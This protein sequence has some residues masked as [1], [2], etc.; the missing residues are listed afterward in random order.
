M[1]NVMTNFLFISSNIPATHL[2][3]VYIIQLVHYSSPATHLYAVY[4]I[5]LVHYSRMSEFYSY[6]LYSASNRYMYAA[7]RLLPSLKVLS[8][9]P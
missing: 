5:Q 8:L 4:I 9:A 3:A 6:F 2:Y 7:A 1:T